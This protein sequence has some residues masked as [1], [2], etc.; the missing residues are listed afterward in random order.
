MAVKKGWASRLRVTGSHGALLTDAFTENTLGWDREAAKRKTEKN[1]EALED[2]Q[3]HLYADNS[4]SL[5]IVLQGIDAGGKDGAVRNVF[6][7]F[8]PQG[9]QEA[10]VMLIG[11]RSRTKRTAQEHMT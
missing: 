1:L 11:N 3:Y 5:L 10:E 4:K 7:A 2:L 8:N 9:T 6:T